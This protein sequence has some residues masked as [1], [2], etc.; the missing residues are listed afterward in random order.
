M[1]EG[2]ISHQQAKHKAE[3][4]Y[5]KF[6]VIQDQKYISD[7]DKLINETNLINDKSE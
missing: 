1:K 7:F 2:D 4:E 5:E 3:I 6:K